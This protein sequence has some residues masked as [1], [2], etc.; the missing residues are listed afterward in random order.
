MYSSMLEQFDKLNIQ[1]TVNCSRELI[2]EENLMKWDHKNP[3]VYIY[4]STYWEEPE[5]VSHRN[6]MTETKIYVQ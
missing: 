2:G 5:R 6:Y 4:V 1:W 3:L